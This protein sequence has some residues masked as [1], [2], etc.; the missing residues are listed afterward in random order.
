MRPM[1]SAL[2]RLRWPL[3]VLA[4]LL[5]PTLVW[6]ELFEQLG[7][8]LDSTAR[9]ARN[10]L[11]AAIW[12]AGAWLLIRLVDVGFWDAIVAPRLGGKVPGLLKD[13]V[14]VAIF[15]LAVT[16]VMA[17]VF[18]L[19]VTGF[20]ATSGV[21]GLV[22]GFAL[23]SM[24]ADVFSGIALNVDRPFQ[25]GDWIRLSNRAREIIIGEVV[26]SNWRSTRIRCVDGTLV[27][28]PN[29]WIARDIVTNLTRPRV[30]SRFEMRFCLDFEVPV[31]RALR[32]LEAGVRTAKGILDAPAP[33]VRVVGPTRTGVEYEIRYWLLCADTSPSKGRHALATAVLDQLHRAGLTLAYEKHDVFTAAMPPRALDIRRHREQIVHR[34]DLFADLQDHEVATLSASMREVR[35][36]RGSDVVRQG[37]Q[38]DSMYILVEGLLDVLV[39]G[40]DGGDVL[41]GRIRAGEF[42]GE[43]S[44]LTGEPRSATVRAATEIVAFEIRKADLEPLFAA[45]RELATAITEKVAERRL[46]SKARL[47]AA[48]AAPPSE[49]ETRSLADQIFGKM[50]GLFGI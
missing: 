12:L 34:V 18:D 40:E 47:E 29:G 3:L 16:G 33:K 46:R 42:F 5:A 8:A 36:P 41:V 20:W 10:G 50:R 25:I 15:S 21:V 7:S 44:L 13:V 35:V 27:V 31:D 37:E 38:G 48:N 1:F 22:L 9:M 2:T 4:L 6:P 28:V 43:M 39:P 14:A 24:I 17:L 19:D 23:Q 11:T 45:R 32:I 30:E 26:E 49:E